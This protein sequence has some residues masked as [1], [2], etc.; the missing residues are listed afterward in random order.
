LIAFCQL[1]NL[2]EELLTLSIFA[3]LIRLLLKGY[4]QAT[5]R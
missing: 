4:C 1:S 2:T 3:R 5:Y